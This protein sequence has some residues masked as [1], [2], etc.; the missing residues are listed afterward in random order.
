MKK[1]FLIP[2]ALTVT[3]GLASMVM[4]VAVLKGQA[5][6]TAT[7]ASK[8]AWTQAGQDLNTVQGYGYKWYLDGSATGN[9]FSGVL[10]SGATPTFDCVVQFPPVTQGNHSIRLS[11]SNAAG[12]GVLSDP[13]AFTFVGKPDKPTNL[14][15]Q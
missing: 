8:L 1:H 11:A 13:F 7:S 4:T 6:P 14:R 9:Q 10:C 12:E 15:I 2:F 5:P 3:L